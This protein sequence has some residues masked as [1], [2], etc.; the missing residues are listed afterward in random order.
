MQGTSGNPTKKTVFDY[1][2]SRHAQSVADAQARLAATTAPYQATIVAAE[3]GIA[4]AHRM[5]VK[6]MESLLEDLR[7][8]WRAHV[9]EMNSELR[10]AFHKFRVKK[11][12]AIRQRQSLMAPFWWSA[13]RKIREGKF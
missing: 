3:Q 7:A 1:L 11:L 2:A 6:T 10:T 5:H 4:L 12:A 9:A 8:D 13:D